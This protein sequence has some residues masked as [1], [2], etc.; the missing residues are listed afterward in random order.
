MLPFAAIYSTGLILNLRWHLI[1]RAHAD[2]LTDKVFVPILLLVVLT[3][4]HFVLIKSFAEYRHN[5]GI[6]A[7]Y[8]SARD[9][10]IIS[11]QRFITFAV[12]AIVIPFIALVVAFWGSWGIRRQQSGRLRQ[13][14]VRPR[15]GFAAAMRRQAL[16]RN[17]EA[18]YSYW[19]I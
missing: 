8:D 14:Y 2:L 12:C 17:T 13:A 15:F 10:E 9:R 4:G 7:E 16:C 5:S 18:G 19:P 3:V 6:C 11:L 1:D